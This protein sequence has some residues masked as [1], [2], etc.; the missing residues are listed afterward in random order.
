M[1]FKDG[2]ILGAD[3]RATAGSI[4]CVKNCQ[5]IHYIA[6]NVYC[7]GAGTAADTQY[8]T[9]K[10]QSECRLL[11]LEADW[12]TIPFNIPKTIIKRHL[13]EHQGH[14]SAALILGGYDK[15]G[16]HLCSIAPHGSS[17]STPFVTMGSGS[18][19]AMAVFENRYKPDMEETEAKKLVRDAVA[20]GVFN[21]LGSGSNI[22][23]CVIKKDKVERFSP[24]EIANKRGA[25]EGNY[26]YPKGS[27]AILRQQKFEIVETQ[28]V[29][30]QPMEE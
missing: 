2:V 15:K 17:D 9:R 24:Y 16:P 12:E 7:C 30:D 25:K 8:V 29:D 6:D 22:N 18:L 20:A 26:K 5:K 4:V 3:T 23:L 27:T 11:M 1:I 10:A 28:V 19:A 21:D 13:F 14:I